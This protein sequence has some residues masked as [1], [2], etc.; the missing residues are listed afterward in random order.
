MHTIS[1]S[2]TANATSNSGEDE[3][4]HNGKENS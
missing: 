3:K 1:E 2:M 4:E